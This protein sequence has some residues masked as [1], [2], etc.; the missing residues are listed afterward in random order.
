MILGDTRADPAELQFDDLNQHV[1][2]NRIVRDHL[3]A[4]EERGLERLVQLRT[5]QLGQ[6]VGIRQ[7][8][9]RLI[10]ASLHH[11]SRADIRRED[12]QRMPE[13]DLTP[14]GIV[15]RA[16]VEHLKEHFQHI[17]VRLLDLVEQDNR[18]RIAPH[19][20]GQ[21]TAFAVA[22]IS[23]RRALQA[24]DA[25]RFLVLA[26]VDRDELA[27]AAVEDIGERQRRFGLADARRPHEQEHTARLVRILEIRAGCAHALC[28]RIER[29]VLA[30]DTLT[31]QVVQAQYGADLVLDHAAE[32]DACPA[33]HDR[34]DD[35]PVHLQR[36]HCARLLQR[37]ELR[38]ELSEFFTLCVRGSRVG[39]SNSS[40]CIR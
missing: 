33:S 12:D 18:V 31:E 28:D 2:G 23:R 14:F 22:H 8:F 25:V 15:E 20:F 19:G 7:R 3:D 40:G 27:L 21:H 5:Q 34:G 36:H 11:G 10:Q 35:V 32:R 38:R 16:F 24:R 39:T 9:R 6:R 13:V 37:F 30:D 26:H 1:V 29:M 17:G 4:A